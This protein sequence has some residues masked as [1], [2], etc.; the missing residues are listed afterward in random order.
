MGIQGLMRGGSVPAARS[1]SSAAPWL[2]AS[3]FSADLGL[4]AAQI[5]SSSGASR[6]GI[7]R[8]PR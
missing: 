6:V 1:A 8:R 3:Q 4:R 7:W 2:R 5:A